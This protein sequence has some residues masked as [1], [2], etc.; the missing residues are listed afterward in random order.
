MQMDMKTQK[1]K[2]TLQFSQVTNVSIHK[3]SHDILS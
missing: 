2:T 3:I 1:K